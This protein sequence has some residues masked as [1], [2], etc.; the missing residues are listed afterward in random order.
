VTFRDPV[1]HAANVTER[2]NVA[3]TLYAGRLSVEHFVCDPDDGVCP[4]D[5]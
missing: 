4:I 2:H 1:T 3:I 5:A